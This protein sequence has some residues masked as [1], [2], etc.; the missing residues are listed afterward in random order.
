MSSTPDTLLD[1]SSALADFA[2]A[3]DELDEAVGKVPDEA[4]GYRP[5]GDDYALG[6]LVVHVTEVLDHYAY[7]LDAMRAVQVGDVRVAEGATIV[8]GRSPGTVASGFASHDRSAV[9][10]AMRS[11][12]DELAAR[13]Q[14]LPAEAYSRKAPVY[15]GD[16]PAPFDTSAADIMGWVTSH[17]REHVAQI[18]DLVAAWKASKS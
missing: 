4:I 9:L 14:A 12:H 18:A 1:R 8:E 11:A 3:R 2:R 10:G 5:P 17:Y 13:V 16:A 6:G 15:F 7:A